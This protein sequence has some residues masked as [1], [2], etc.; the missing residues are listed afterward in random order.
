MPVPIHENRYTMISFTRTIGFRLWLI[1]VAAIM[2]PLGINIFQLN[3]LQYK[4]TLLSTTSDLRENALFKAH[5][6]QQIIPLNIDILAL[7]SE[8]FDLDRGVPSEPDLALS[9]E[10]EKIFYSTYKEISC[11]KGS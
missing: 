3:L 1:C 2:F 7:F 11:K 4:K 8:I 6:L 9:K 10:M 5:T